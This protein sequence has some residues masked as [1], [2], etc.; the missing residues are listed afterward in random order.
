MK[1][2]TRNVEDHGPPYR[3]ELTRRNLMTL[4]AKLDDPI[5]DRTLIDPDELVMVVAVEDAEHY[6][7]RRPGFVYMPNSGVVF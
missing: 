2:L 1:F 3:L 6:A 5:S 4:L 7:E